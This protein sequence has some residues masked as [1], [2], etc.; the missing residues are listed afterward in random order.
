LGACPTYMWPCCFPPGGQSGADLPDIPTEQSRSLSSPSLSLS[1]E[2]IPI[3]V[4]CLLIRSPHRSGQKSPSLPLTC[5]TQGPAA[6][7]VPRP[8]CVYQIICQLARPQA[9]LLCHRWPWCGLPGAPPRRL[10]RRVPA[11][12]P[13]PPQLDLDGGHW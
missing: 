11:R 6:S 10:V 1:K 12:L 3:A 4:H 13:A 8:T 9:K 7:S 5:S 2:K